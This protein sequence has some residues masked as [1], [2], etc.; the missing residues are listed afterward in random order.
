LRQV[1]T[2]WDFKSSGSAEKWRIK[3]LGSESGVTRRSGGQRWLNKKAQK[4]FRTFPFL[5][6]TVRLTNISW[7]FSLGA[8]V[9]F[10]PRRDPEPPSTSFVR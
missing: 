2:E 3:K 7:G 1:A 6:S 5:Y 8:V 9:R 4:W 10:T